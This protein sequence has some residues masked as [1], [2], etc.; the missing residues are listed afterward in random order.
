M[1]NR[2]RLIVL[3]SIVAL[4]AGCSNNPAGTVEKQDTD[5]YEVVERSRAAQSH[6]QLSLPG[7]STQPVLVSTS[8]PDTSDYPESS[9]IPKKVTWPD[10][11]QAKN[12]NSSVV[13][14][15]LQGPS[16]PLEATVARYAEVDSS[17]IPQGDPTVETCTFGSTD[18]FSSCSIDQVLGESETS[19]VHIAAANPEDRYFAF[20]ATWVVDTSDGP[21]DLMLAWGFQIVQ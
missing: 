15:S 4:L 16:A 7:G 3:S 5:G 11:S 9:P 17:G 13:D 18:L 20:Q 14:L 10:L 2:L 12:Q 21:E 6:Y 19:S 8:W 1:E